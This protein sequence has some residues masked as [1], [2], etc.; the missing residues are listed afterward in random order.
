MR[1]LFFSGGV[2]DNTQTDEV[3]IRRLACGGVH[4][5]PCARAR[6][7]AAHL[8]AMTD[9]PGS[10]VRRVR[11]EERTVIGGGGGGDDF[12]GGGG[13]ASGGAGPSRGV[14]E[15][16][17]ATA[18]AG[19]AGN[20]T[21]ATSTSAAAAAAASAYRRLPRR[22]A[23]MMLQRHLL[24]FARLR[25]L[26]KATGLRPVAMLGLPAVASFRTLRSRGGGGGGGGRGN[27]RVGVGG[28][29]GERDTLAFSAVNASLQGVFDVLKHEAGGDRLIHSTQ[30]PLKTVQLFA[31]LTPST[32]F[33]HPAP[34]TT[35]RIK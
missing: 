26:P 29:G 19:D 24:G 12:D 20:T 1:V 32:C 34:P 33:H 5:R 28:R 11:F 22:R 18:A 30:P 13:M 15:C 3:K 9:D 27:H 16:N 23:R 21:A 10:E 2:K 31:A 6:L 14:D 8:A 35:D 7:T 4:G 25:L 17:A